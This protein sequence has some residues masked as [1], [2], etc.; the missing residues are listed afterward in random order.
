MNQTLE[1]AIRSDFEVW[2][3]GFPPDSEQQIFL[4]VTTASSKEW[5][6][7]IV[8]ESLRAWM[9]AEESSDRVR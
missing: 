2:S 3:G 8:L 9:V 4:Y 7:N 1:A 5:D 6:D